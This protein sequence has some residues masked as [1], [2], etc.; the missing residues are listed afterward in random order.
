MI[1]KILILPWIWLLVTFT[2]N[3]IE[4]VSLKWEMGVNGIVKGYY[5]NRFVLTNNT[6]M[7]LAANWSLYFNQMPRTIK[8]DSQ[9]PVL[10][11][12]INADYFKLSPSNFYQPI[13]PHDSIIISFMA[14]NGLIKESHAPNGA[15]W[16]TTTDKK[17]TEPVSIPIDV[18]PFTNENQ[19]SRPLVPELPYP[20]GDRIFARNQEIGQGNLAFQDI[21][22]SVKNYQSLG[23]KTALKERV[24]IVFNA[25]FKNEQ[26]ILGDELLSLYQ[27]K[28]D[29]NSSFKIVLE[30]L[31]SSVASRNK[32]YYR[33]QIHHNEILIQG[34]QPIA[35]FDGIQ[36][37][38]SLL[39]KGKLLDNCIITDYPDLAYRGQL[40]DVARNFMPKEE[41]MKLIELF[42]SYKINT[43]H[44]H[45][46]DDEGW[47][48]E[49]KGLEELTQIGARRG[50][51]HDELTSLFPAFGSGWSATNAQSS[52]NGFYS[53][54]DF[55]EILQFA[56]KH[57]VT[58]IPEIDF[59][60]HARAAIVSMK[61][62]YNKY[63]ATDPAKAEEFLLSDFADSSKYQSAQ[64]YTDNVVN[65]ALPSTYR[66]INKVTSE[67]VDIYREAQIPLSNIHIG[68]DE[69]PD[70]AWIG[71][72]IFRS[73]EEKYRLKK[74]EFSS[75]FFKR[76]DSIFQ[77]YHL[78]ML[79]WQEIALT[80]KESVK[81]DLKTITDGVYCW[82]TVSEWGGDV[83]PYNLANA[84]YNVILCNVSNFYFDLAYN[85]HPCERGLY[86]AGFVDEVSSFNMLPFDI[87][88]SNRTNFKGEKNNL[89]LQ[90]KG[91][92]RLNKNAISR[93]KGVQ[94]ELFSENIPNANWAQY[95]LFPKMFGLI[96][97]GWNAYPAWAAENDSTREAQLY[98]KALANYLAK[99]AEIELPY[100]AKKNCNFRIEQPGITIIN[101]SIYAN[102]TLKNGQIRFTT[103]GR[104]PTS[105]DRLWQCPVKY[106]GEIL[107]AKCFFLNKESVTTIYQ[108]EK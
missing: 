36:T 14:T 92:P 90:E 88:K 28:N 91:K 85:K 10:I 4:P 44:L 43:L 98:Q 78:R 41:L 34:N 73:M 74:E 55:I 66:F 63:I 82:N 35:I 22:P 69:V 39:K 81:S 15:Y 31:P 5:S 87:Y 52:G 13:P 33:L 70:G 42:S 104:E 79:G 26:E 16:V 20:S 24:N 84:G 62:R 107:K 6:E 65:I 72:P 30:K 3:S 103:D 100:L 71:S 32:E 95:A 23:G 57:H 27:I 83:I 97:R 75:G 53:R 64:G 21:L 86:W 94:G 96:E 46:T 2:I 40:I 105:T 17:E 50:H 37:F 106:N 80:K 29:G 89:R 12:K 18:V 58:V 61:A 9:A 59:P 25:A 101:D 51:T 93:I 56:A 77:P 45:A 76:V 38:L 60:G 102:T 99:I 68:G 67:I 47:R 11:S 48:I 54:Q 49:I 108:P 19:W 1:R 7:P 8:Q